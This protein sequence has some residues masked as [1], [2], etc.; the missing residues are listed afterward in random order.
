MQNVS[1]LDDIQ[2]NPIAHGTYSTTGFTTS[3]PV[4]TAPAATNAVTTVPPVGT[5]VSPTT[6]PCKIIKN[7]V[8]YLKMLKAYKKI[9]TTA[10]CKAKCAQNKTC[11]YWVWS[12]KRQCKLF[13]V[14]WKKSKNAISG[15]EC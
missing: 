5:T 4:G 13:D 3:A 10:I 11:Q 1:V 15:E 14:D 8:P 7:V 12:R 2:G 9:K 6:T